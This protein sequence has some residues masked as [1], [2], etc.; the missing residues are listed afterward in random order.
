MR[1]C[2]E[3]GCP[4]L[5]NA[6][7]CDG[8]R[9]AKRR[10]EDK[11]RP[12]ARQRGYDTRWQRTRAAYLAAFPICQHPDGCLN[13]ATDVDH[14]DGWGPNGPRGHDFGNLRGYC[15]SHHSE[16]TA[17]DQPGGWAA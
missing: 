7:R 13:P 15:H 10:A 8:C 5:T 11:R 3:P 4:T 2:A 17:R 12:N 6:T 16:R 9:K 14:I 1:V